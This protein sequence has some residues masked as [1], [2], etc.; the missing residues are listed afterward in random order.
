[1]G[2]FTRPF[3]HDGTKRP[4]LRRAFAILH[5]GRRKL[6]KRDDFMGHDA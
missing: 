1:M 2:V 4:Y 6:E 5:L 3:E